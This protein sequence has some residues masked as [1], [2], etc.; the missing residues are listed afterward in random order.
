MYRSFDE[1]P[2]EDQLRWQAAFKTGDRFDDSGPGAHLA[3][4]TRKVWREAY[5]RFV[6]YVE[7]HRPEL[8]G[9][10]PNARIDRLIV[11]DYVA[12]RRKSCSDVS[13]AIDLDHLRGALKLICP[14][15][16]WSWLLT[17]TKRIAAM[18]PR[19]LP[20]YNQVTSERLYALG[21]E[22]MDD[23]VA[24]ADKGRARIEG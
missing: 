24:A 9:E 12:Y 3:E 1:W 6:G 19:R 15:A 21:L 5:G 18:A 10:A 4:S 2:V 20:K 7:T 22:V 8:L 23:A 17:I 11:A 14:G 16:D 13:I